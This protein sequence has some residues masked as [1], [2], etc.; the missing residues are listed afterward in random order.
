MLVLERI[1]NQN[2]D[3]ANLAYQLLTWLTYCRRPLTVTEIQHAMAVS[4]G[5]ENLYPDDLIDP[6]ILL[7]VCAGIVVI[8]KQSLVIRLIHYTTEEYLRSIRQIHHKFVGGPEII[9]RICATY[10]GSRDFEQGF[11]MNRNAF[12]KALKPFP[13]YEYAATFWADHAKQGVEE[14][15]QREMLRFLLHDK[16]ASMVARCT[17][18]SW[19]G[20][21]IQYGIHLAA[22]FGLTVTM[23]NLLTAGTDVLSQDSF[24]KTALHYACAAR[25]EAAVSFV[26]S[27]QNAVRIPQVAW[28]A[29]HLAVSY[30]A[31]HVVE[32]LLGKHVKDLMSEGSTAQI[33]FGRTPL[34]RAVLADHNL[35]NLLLSKLPSSS[36]RADSFGMTALHIA[37]ICGKEKAVQALLLGGVSP[38][39]VDNYKCTPLLYAVERDQDA[40][41]QMLL[42]YGT[43]ETLRCG[44]SPILSAARLGKSSVLER[45]L[46]EH[47][48]AVNETDASGWTALHFAAAS[49]YPETVA[50]L[51]RNGADVAM[52]TCDGLTASDLELSSMV[53]N[54]CI[55][56]Y[57]AVPEEGSMSIS[58]D[59]K[60]SPE[61]AAKLRR[62]KGVLQLQKLLT[63]AEDFIDAFTILQVFEMNDEDSDGYLSQS[64]FSHCIIEIKHRMITFEEAL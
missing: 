42:E 21:P 34:H 38:K 39:M 56:P 36:N 47:P 32:M 49:R 18:K 1:Q 15:S 63:D 2:E 10:L 54:R 57:P 58:H 60:P 43:R 48:T 25:D 17:D 23:S 19:Y 16:K 24:G 51:L 26:I 8:E 61:R 27:H 7:S 6:D 59:A 44:K 29:I 62:K 55:P 20:T 22:R 50:V 13:F 45:L 64:L 41:V 37:S 30:N 46:K 33:Y 53:S 4:L 52:R 5:D 12:K 9:T 14:V 11:V 3:D 40:I 31:Y 35:I 28:L